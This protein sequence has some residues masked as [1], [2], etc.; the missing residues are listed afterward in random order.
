MWGGC[1]M[2]AAAPTGAGIP[3]PEARRRSGG[4][5]PARTTRAR[6]TTSP[7]ALSTIVQVAPVR[8]P[9]APARTVARPRAARPRPGATAPPPVARL[10][11][12]RGGASKRCARRS[13]PRR[14]RA[15]YAGCGAGGGGGWLV[16]PRPASRAAPVAAASR[17]PR[18]R[19]H[20]GAPRRWSPRSVSAPLVAAGRA[21]SLLSPR[22]VRPASSLRPVAGLRSLFSSGSRRARLRAGAR[23]PPSRRC[24]S[25]VGSWLAAAPP[26][27][28]G[29]RA[30]AAGPPGRFA[31]PRQG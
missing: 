18:A 19:A 24:S 17:P 27:P 22:P 21:P 15:P 8:D 6:G 26:L 10:T 1:G 16:L 14:G 9:A 11:P 20:C 28:G 5:C 23:C 13:L 7:S 12:W 3:A 2:A 25:V 29:R 4:P 30:R 31:P